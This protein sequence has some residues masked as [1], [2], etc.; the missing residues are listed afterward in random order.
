MN[1]NLL[2]PI[3]FQ[4]VLGNQCYPNVSDTFLWAPVENG[5]VWYMVPPVTGT[6][7]QVEQFCR[8]LD[9][10]GNRSALA[11]FYNIAQLFILMSNTKKFI[12]HKSHI[13]NP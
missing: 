2:F 3:L 10:S 11:K 5:Q 13:L 7:S 1:F 8:N 9:K 6:W 12:S 4:S